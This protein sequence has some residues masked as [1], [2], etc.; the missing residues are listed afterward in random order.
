MQCRR[1][2]DHHLAAHLGA[3][4]SHLIFPLERVVDTMISTPLGRMEL[5]SDLILCFNLRGHRDGQSREQ[6]TENRERTME[7][8]LHSSVVPTPS[9]KVDVEKLMS[10]KK[11]AADKTQAV[12]IHIPIHNSS[13]WIEFE[14]RCHPRPKN[15][16]YFRSLPQPG[17]S[18]VFSTSWQFRSLDPGEVL[19]EILGMGAKHHDSCRRPCP[20]LRR[21]EGNSHHFQGHPYRLG[22]GR[23][24]I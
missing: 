9:R 1:R 11:Q 18:A 3:R 19:E 2:C 16:L 5:K 17:I 7:D 15:T 8:S 20:P 24:P 6:R 10:T 23:Y 21:R 22:V 12:G 13:R 4:S 14:N